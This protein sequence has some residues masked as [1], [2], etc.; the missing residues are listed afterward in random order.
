MPVTGTIATRMIIRATGNVGIGISDPGA[1][2]LHVEG[3]MIA[4]SYATGHII[5][6]RIYP[7]KGESFEVGDILSI[8][9][10]SESAQ[11]T[12]SARFTKSQ[13]AYD[14]NIVGV[15]EYN[16]TDGFK[17]TFAGVFETKVSTLNGPIRAGDPIT[18]SEI[19]GVGMKATKAGPIVGKALEPYDNPDPDAV[20]KIMVFV[21]VSWYDPDVYLTDTGDLKIV[22]NTQNTQSVGKSENQN[23]GE[24]EKFSLVDSAGRVIER[25]GAF[26]EMVVAKIQAGLIETKQ[27]IVD[28][29][30]IVKKLNELEVENDLLKAR[31]EAIEAKLNP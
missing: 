11:A 25:V 20:G 23:I 2:K 13:K 27:L 3:G 21:N 22:Q 18:S 10:A 24:S 16:E 15:A 19:P 28:G 17:P 8:T 6:S 29:I 9:D 14:Q 5:E 26:A 7:K 4:Q 1:Y 12:E 30:D 31:I